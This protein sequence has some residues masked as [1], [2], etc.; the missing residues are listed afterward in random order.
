[1]AQWNT[2]MKM[3]LHS[4]SGLSLQVNTL[5]KELS[6]ELGQVMGGAYISHTPLY[7]E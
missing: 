6:T 4:L 7:C 5:S 3:V 1:M 2:I